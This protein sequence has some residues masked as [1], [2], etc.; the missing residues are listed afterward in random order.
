MTDT[1]QTFLMK[2]LIK[3]GIMISSLLPLPKFLEL[4]LGLEAIF[5][6]E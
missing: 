6:K 1:Y 2:M 4:P 3:G 5:Q